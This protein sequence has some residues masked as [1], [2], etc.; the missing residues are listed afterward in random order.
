M[1]SRMGMVCGV[2]C[3]TG[4][5]TSGY[6]ILCKGGTE[7]GGGVIHRVT[8]TWWLLGLAV[9]APWLGLCGQILALAAWTHLE[10]AMLTG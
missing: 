5:S 2:V 3:R 10:N 1:D 8:C 6:I 7:R 9:K 4:S